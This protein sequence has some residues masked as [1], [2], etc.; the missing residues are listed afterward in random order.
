ME[1]ELMRGIVNPKV[2]ENIIKYISIIDFD[3][4][5]IYET[6]HKLSFYMLSD[7]FDSDF[8]NALQLPWFTNL[9]YDIEVLIQ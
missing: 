2:L 4:K 9:K 7:K 3:P 1:S 8:P 6:L 5:K